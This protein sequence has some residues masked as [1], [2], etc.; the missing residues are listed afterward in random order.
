[1][2]LEG[3][4]VIYDDDYYFM[5]SVLAEKLRDEG[6]EVIYVTPEVDVAHWTHNTM[7]QSRIQARLLELGVDIHTSRKLGAIG[8]DNVELCCTYTGHATALDAG[9][10]V[11]VTMRLPEDALYHE[12]MADNAALKAAGI[13]SVTRIGDCLAPG[14]I[15]AAVY[16]GHKYARELDAQLPSNDDVPFRR[17]TMQL[18][19]DWPVL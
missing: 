13:A 4:V 18:S 15:A 14:L 10:V 9:S 7:E 19:N 8:A 2:E 6:H 11:L 3:P 12:L 17:E 1:V 16:G 5:A